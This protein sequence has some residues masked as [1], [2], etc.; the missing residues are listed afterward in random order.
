MPYGLQNTAF[1]VSS[2]GITTLLDRDFSMPVESRTPDIARHFTTPVEWLRPGAYRD[3]GTPVDSTEGGAAAR[4]Q[5]FQQASAMPP[6]V[7]QKFITPVGKRVNIGGLDTFGGVLS[8]P[9]RSFNVPDGPTQDSGLG[10]G[11]GLIGRRNDIGTPLP[12]SQILNGPLFR[13]LVRVPVIPGPNDLSI[14]VRYW[15]DTPADRPSIIIKAS[16]V[17]G[18]P[19][20]IEV[21]APAGG[22]TG[23][24]TI[25][26]TIY[27]ATYGALE[28]YRTGR[29][30]RRDA[31]TF[32]DNLIVQ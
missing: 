2:D 16:D 20:D 32:W 14:S 27:A 24:V 30:V 13:M 25:Q 28:V 15:P 6:V 31:Y 8:G 9:I 18:I 11:N 23:F 29:S 10:L 19:E 12:P 22:E 3:F 1:W 26:R 7:F 4:I 21:I 5:L 17:L